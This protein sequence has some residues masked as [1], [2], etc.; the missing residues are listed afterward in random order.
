MVCALVHGAEDGS[1][2]GLGPWLG[3]GCEGASSHIPHSG[4]RAMASVQTR[5]PSD[6]VVARRRPMARLKGMRAT[7]LRSLMRSY[8]ALTARNTILNTAK[9]RFHACGTHAHAAVRG[10]ESFRRPSESDRETHN[11]GSSVAGATG[12]SVT[13]ADDDDTIA[14]QAAYRT[15]CLITIANSAKS[16]GTSKSRCFRSRPACFLTH[17]MARIGCLG[18]HRAIETST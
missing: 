8:E 4:F 3:V 9:P 14:C 10:V 17:Q 11:A 2:D 16:T 15:R 12:L 18:T 1:W 13:S 6:A 7:S 5:G